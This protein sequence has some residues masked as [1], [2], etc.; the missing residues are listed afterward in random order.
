MTDK[1]EKL[2]EIIDRSHRIVFFG[3]AGVST[4]SGIPD[5]R[6]EDGLYHQKYKF[7]PEYMLSH[8]CFVDR[9]EDFYDFYRDKIL[10]YDAKPNAAH[11]FLA[12]LERAGKLTA[13]VTQNIDGLHDDAG[14]KYVYELHGSVRRNHCT[15]CG[16]FYTLDAVKGGSGVPHCSCGGVI[17]PDVVLYGEGLDDD[18]VTGA[19]K[20]I[21]DA[22]A[23]II[24]GTSLTVYPAAGLIRYFRGRDLVV[25]NLGDAGD[26]TTLAVVPEAAKCR[27]ILLCKE[28]EMA[29]CGL[30]VA[31]R[32]FRAVDP[33][34]EFTALKREGDICRRGDVLAEISGSAR[35]V[36]TAERTA[37][38]FIQRLSGA[39]TAAHR[40]AAAVA[41]TKTVVLDTRKTTPGYRNLEKYAVAVG[42]AGNHRI[43]LYDRVMIKDNHR[44]MAAME[45]DGAIPRAVARARRAYPG[46]EI[47][48]E[49]DTLDEVRAAAECGVEH[50]MLDNMDDETMKEAVGIVAGRAKLEASGGIT[51][52]R[53]PRIAKLGVDFISVGALTHSVKSADI[54]LDIEVEK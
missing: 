10:S 54:S 33:T 34:L 51:L 49:A 13:V 36:L 46:L 17:K 35:S 4:E 25:I 14:S 26:V 47:E 5:F 41:G 42:G 32:V 7:P 3:G 38:N 12:A 53:L 52:E 8:E 31:E 6:S 23:M 28:P 15:R 19:I 22:D 18:T 44:E 39:A 20:A 48:V 37:L 30:P 11:L 29:L 40:Y 16:A 2:Q 21:A 45:G 43:G 27:A 24:A 50:I 1:I 9:T